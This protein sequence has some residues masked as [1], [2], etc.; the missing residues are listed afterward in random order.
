MRLREVF[1]VQ[2]VPVILKRDGYKCAR[3]GNKHSLQVHHIRHF[4]DI[5]NQ[6]LINNPELD[7]IKDQNKLYEKAL[8]MPE[9]TD[10]NNLITYCKECHLFYIHGYKH[11]SQAHYKSPEL[12]GNLTVKDEDNQQL[13]LSNKESSTTISKESTSKQMEAG[14]LSDKS[15]SDDMV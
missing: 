7:P 3:C 13:S 4:S 1:K 2:Q 14:G 8:N 15:E 6:L 11:N 5:L 12:L 10:L 9:F